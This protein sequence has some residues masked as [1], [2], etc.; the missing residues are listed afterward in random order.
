MQN[1]RAIRIQLGLSLV[2]FGAL[3]GIDRSVVSRREMRPYSFQSAISIV[4]WFIGQ[5][6]PRCISKL[7]NYW[8]DVKPK[9]RENTRLLVRIANRFKGPG[10]EFVS[11]ERAMRKAHPEFF[12]SEQN[13][14]PIDL[15]N[16][17]HVDVL[18]PEPQ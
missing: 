8:I 7:L 16:M 6:P 3:L 11:W 18:I 14:T 4:Y 5:D 12:P 9:N 13:R 10:F 1:F 2:E 17:N 15:G